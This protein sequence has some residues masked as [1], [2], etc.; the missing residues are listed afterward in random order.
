MHPQRDVELNSFCIKLQIVGVI[1][2]L[3]CWRNNKTSADRIELIHSPV[4]LCKHDVGIQGRKDGDP[5]KSCGVLRGDIRNLVVDELC[6][7]NG[8]LQDRCIH[9]GKL[10]ETVKGPGC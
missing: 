1:G 7:L 3:R 6:R 10:R 8:L 5:F 2:R 9:L 4:K